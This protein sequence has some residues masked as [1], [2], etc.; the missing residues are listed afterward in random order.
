MDTWNC[1]TPRST[2]NAFCTATYKPELDFSSHIAETN[3]NKGAATRSQNK[4]NLRLAGS[5]VA[6]PS[7]DS[8]NFATIKP[9]DKTQKIKKGGI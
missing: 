5:M 4:M 7:R 3:C 9:S 8:I 2:G 1:G 6:I